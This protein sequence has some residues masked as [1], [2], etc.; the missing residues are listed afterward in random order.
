MFKHLSHGTNR[1]KVKYAIG[2]EKQYDSWTCGLRA[3]AYITYR[4]LD[5]DPRWYLLC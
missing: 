2:L 3:V 1:I 5:H 4:A